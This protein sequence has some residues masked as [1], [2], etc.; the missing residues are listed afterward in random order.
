MRLIITLLACPFHFLSLTFLS[1]YVVL[2]NLQPI[3]TVL[4]ASPATF[5]PPNSVF[6][7]GLRFSSS[8]YFAAIISRTLVVWQVSFVF[9]GLS[10]GL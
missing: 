3:T 6:S 1:N 7:Q 5:N 4:M 9:Q 10:K 2:I 8:D